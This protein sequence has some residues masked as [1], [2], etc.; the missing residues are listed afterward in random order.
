MAEGSLRTCPHP[1]SSLTSGTS[2]AQGLRVCCPAAW[3][4]LRTPFREW[5]TLP[6]HHAL[7]APPTSQPPDPSAQLSANRIFLL[8]PGAHLSGR[9]ALSQ[10]WER[11]EPSGFVCFGHCCIVRARTGLRCAGDSVPACRRPHA[12]TAGHRES[13]TNGSQT[14]SQTGLRLEGALWGAMLPPEPAGAASRAAVPWLSCRPLDQPRN[15]HR[16]TRSSRPPC[17]WAGPPAPT[18]SSGND[19]GMGL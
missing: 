3:D 8:T 2:P 13:S 18:P 14:G 15:V 4:S 16:Q 1:D 11:P 5:L 7:S 12:A 10:G 19:A 6:P 17:L 9:L